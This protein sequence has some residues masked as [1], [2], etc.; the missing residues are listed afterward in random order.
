M[1]IQDKGQ[2]IG[3]YEETLVKQK[4][5]WKWSM[6]AIYLDSKKKH[7]IQYTLTA[8]LDK[9]L[10][11]SSFSGAYSNLLSS[12]RTLYKGEKKGGKFLFTSKNITQEIPMESIPQELLLF[13]FI[14]QKEKQ[15]TYQS[16]QVRSGEILSWKLEL[17][18]T[19]EESIPWKDKKN[20]ATLGIVKAST[21]K[22]QTIVCRVVLSG[23]G[24]EPGILLNR[25]QRQIQYLWVSQQDFLRAVYGWGTR[26]Y[27]KEKQLKKLKDCIARLLDQNSVV[28]FQAVREIEYLGLWQGIPGIIEMLQDKDEKVRNMAYDALCRMTK[29]KFSPNIQQWRFWW[30]NY[31]KEQKEQKEAK[32]KNEK[33]EKTYE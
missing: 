3:Y 9:N 18:E 15:V 33:S 28:R 29:Q 14:A 2:T 30:I 7:T 23:G 12:K 24:V 27:D 11:L 22:S 13:C 21:T 26:D 31:Q 32:K 4:E 1:K 17:E 19:S 8:I 20:K 16:L 5:H 10:S 6:Q 25:T